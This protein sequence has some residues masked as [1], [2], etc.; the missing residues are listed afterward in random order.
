M[1]KQA[2]LDN[3]FL[4]KLSADELDSFHSL[5]ESD[6]L[7]KEQF[8]FEAN[9]QKVVR[10]EERGKLKTK[11]QGYEKERALTNEKKQRSWRPLLIA[12]SIA[13]LFM[14]AW[15][16]N[17]NVAL[18]TERL[19]AQNHTS[20][21]NTVYPITR[22]ESGDNSIERKAFEAYEAGDYRLAIDDF[23]KIHIADQKPYVDFYKGQSHLNLGQVEEAKSAFAKTIVS[24]SGFVPEAHWY[25]ALIAL[26]EKDTKS[27]ITSLKKLTAEFDYNKDKALE[28]LN[29]LE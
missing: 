13:L 6:K 29:E 24:D 8:E 9:L 15:Y 7:F 17:A 1:D 23:N 11:L 28:L 18:D 4:N 14:G 27:A 2:L 10:H 20:Y 25:L 16:Y 3:Y 26:K 22:G 19:Y 5:L 21:P 12:A